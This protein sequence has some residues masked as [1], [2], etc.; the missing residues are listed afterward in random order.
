MWLDYSFEK[1]FG[2]TEL[3]TPATSDFYYSQIEEKLS[4]PEF[5]P[6]ALFDRFNIEVL[7]TTDSAIS[8]LSQHIEIK[9]SNWDGRIIPTYRPDNRNR[10]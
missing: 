8:D 2:I 6:Q 5:L 9:N 10:S 7:S 1:V 4:E 3:L